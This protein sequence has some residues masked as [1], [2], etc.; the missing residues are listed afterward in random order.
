MS[1]NMTFSLR[2]HLARLGPPLALAGLAFAPFAVGSAQAQTAV[3]S[4]A[5]TC[6]HF[7][8]DAP[9]WKASLIDFV[10]VN[11]PKDGGVRAAASVE[12]KGQDGQPIP[13]RLNLS[14]CVR[15]DGDKT[16][17]SLQLFPWSPVDAE[18]N[19]EL[20][21][22]KLRRPNSRFAFLGFDERAQNLLYLI[23]DAD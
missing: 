14:V 21:I 3:P 12:S 5:W 23:N 18:G 16:N 1:K 15:N 10:R 9:D 7:A 17:Y 22:R 8:D 11:G 2:R 20:L 13:A 19:F 6:R 4:G